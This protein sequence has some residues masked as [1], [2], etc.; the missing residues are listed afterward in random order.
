MRTRNHS[1]FCRVGVGYSQKVKWGRNWMMAHNCN[2]A[3]TQLRGYTTH[4]QLLHNAWWH[5]TCNH[6]S[7]FRHPHCYGSWLTQADSQDTLFSELLPLWQHVYGSCGRC[8]MERGHLYPLLT[9]SRFL[10]SSLPPSTEHA[11]IQLKY[12]LSAW[13]NPP[14]MRHSL[15]EIRVSLHPPISNLRV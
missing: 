8:T 11:V 7:R 12:S 2:H 5:T 13:A 6:K 9:I 1:F 10:S 14:R 15:R 4:T 3:I